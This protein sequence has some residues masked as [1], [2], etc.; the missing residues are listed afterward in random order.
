MWDFHYPAHPM[1]RD[2]RKYMRLCKR[3]NAEQRDPY[4]NEWDWIIDYCYP[5]ENRIL[6]MLNNPHIKEE[7]QLVEVYNYTSIN[8]KTGEK[9]DIYMKVPLSEKEDYV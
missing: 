4:P 2:K 1:D 8:M 5:E 3:L 7:E 9:E 6:D